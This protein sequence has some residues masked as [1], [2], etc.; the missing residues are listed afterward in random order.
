MLS[1]PHFYG[2]QKGMFK[3]ITSGTILQYFL[4]LKGIG[5]KIPSEHLKQKPIYAMF[6]QYIPMIKFNL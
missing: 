3:A 1:F 5:S 2:Y 6:F 4:N